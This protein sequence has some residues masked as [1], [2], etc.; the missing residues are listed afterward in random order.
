MNP[1]KPEAHWHIKLFAK[2][3]HVPLFLQGVDAQ[4]ER[5]TWPSPGPGPG[6]PPLDPGV[7]PIG[8]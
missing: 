2:G 7:H 8:P 5:V 6:R 3:I 4:G 1:V